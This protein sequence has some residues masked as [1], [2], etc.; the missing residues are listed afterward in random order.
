MNVFGVFLQ[1]IKDYTGILL[2]KEYFYNVHLLKFVFKYIQ[3]C[4]TGHFLFQ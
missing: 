1:F 2:L 3:N 4:D